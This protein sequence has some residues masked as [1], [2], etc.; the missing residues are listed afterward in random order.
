LGIGGCREQCSS[1]EKTNDGIQTKVYFFS[2]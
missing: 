2:D 1:G